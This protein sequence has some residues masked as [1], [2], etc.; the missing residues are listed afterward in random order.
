MTSV[1]L[2]DIRRLQI[3][4]RDWVDPNSTRD[5]RDF[6]YSHSE[7]FI[8]RTF[9]RGDRTV[10]PYYTDRMRQWDADKYRR[11]TDGG[12]RMTNWHSVPKSPADA[13]A[14]VRDYFG[15][16][17]ECVGVAQSINVSN[18]YPIGVIFIRRPAEAR[19]RSA[20][21]EVNHG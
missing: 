12:D 3:N 14:L 7:Y 18:G 4:G 8:W 9:E 13:R 20:L 5:P 16:E 1:Y 10:E 6:P 11:A 21:G 19:I 2:D 17:F 15:T